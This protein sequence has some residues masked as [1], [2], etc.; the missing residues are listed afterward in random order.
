MCVC[1]WSI[2]V[3]CAICSHLN[4]TWKNNSINNSL[5]VFEMFFGMQQWYQH[6]HCDSCDLNWSTPCKNDLLFF[7]IQYF[8]ESMMSLETIFKHFTVHACTGWRN[9]SGH[10]GPNTRYAFL[11]CVKTI[12]KKNYVKNI[13]MFC[14]DWYSVTNINAYYSVTSCQDQCNAHHFLWDQTNATMEIPRLRA[15]QD[16]WELPVNV[17]HWLQN[18]G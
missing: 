12:K 3:R 8:E 14:D 5:H 17:L 9:I 16:G 6:T 11:E 7:K 15:I 1:V 10:L 4:S 18:V 13:W 2:N